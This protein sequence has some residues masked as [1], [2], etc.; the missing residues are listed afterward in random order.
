MGAWGRGLEFGR[1]ED[2]SGGEME[3]GLGWMEISG[4]VCYKLQIKGVIRFACRCSTAAFMHD[5]N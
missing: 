5:N 2:G 3:V 4:R 1:D